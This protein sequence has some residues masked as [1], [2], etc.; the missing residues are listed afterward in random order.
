[1]PPEEILS[2]ESLNGEFFSHLAP[3]ASVASNLF[4]FYLC[5][6]RSVFW[7]RIRIHNTVLHDTYAGDVPED[8]GPVHASH[9][10][11]PPGKTNINYT[12]LLETA[13]YNIVD[14]A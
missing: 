1:M 8:W 11:H 3:V 2:V 7:L 5:G 9:A 13:L 12:S 10:L 4:Y 14:D 6:S